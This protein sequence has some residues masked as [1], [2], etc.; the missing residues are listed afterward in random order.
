MTIRDRFNQI[1]QQM[2]AAA[3]AAGRDPETVRLVA[4]SK[5][6]PAADVRAVA[7]AGARLFGENYIQE[8]R[9]KVRALSDLTLTWH[10]VGHLQRN[11][12]KYAVRWFDLI[13]SVDS[14]TL[15]REIHRQAEKFGKIQPIL[16]QAN[17]SGE[18]SK[19]GAAAADIHD[20]VQQ[21][22]QLDH[23]RID[24]LMTMPPFF[25]DPERARPYFRQLC[26]IRDELRIQKIPNAPLGELSMGMTGDYKA[27]I[28]E[29]ATL[30]RIGTAIFG[31][32]A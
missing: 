15:A 29:G 26:Q 6:R 24:G 5:T 7:E 3:V 21:A 31:A 16:I 2:T 18:A 10:F 30:V 17:L 27:A 11:K 8:A 13:H 25:D 32:R 19:S 9:G 14:L 23:L 20:L 12:A 4:I 28:A 1:Q 22:A